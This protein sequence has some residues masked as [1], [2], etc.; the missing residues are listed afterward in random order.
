[1]FGQNNITGQSKEIKI[2]SKNRIFIP[3]YTEVEAGEEISLMYDLYRKKLL[4]LELKE[5]ED[6]ADKFIKELDRLVKDTK[7]L[8]TTI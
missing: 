7:R 3:N 2:D 8:R 4:I 1:M 5:F 6:K